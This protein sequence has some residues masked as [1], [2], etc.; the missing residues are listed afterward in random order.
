MWANHVFQELLPLLWGSEA[1]F[2]NMLNCFEK[3]IP[4]SSLEL[5]EMSVKSKRIFGI[6]RF[7]VGAQQVAFFLKLVTELDIFPENVMKTRTV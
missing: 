6:Y 7:D 5:F 3:P 2:R 4:C 1:S